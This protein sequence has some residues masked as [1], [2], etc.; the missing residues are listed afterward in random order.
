MRNRNIKGQWFPNH[1]I[2]KFPLYL[3]LYL[4]ALQDLDGYRSVN[5]DLFSNFVKDRI[6]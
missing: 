6:F 4:C 2:I 3:N 5:D 1:Y